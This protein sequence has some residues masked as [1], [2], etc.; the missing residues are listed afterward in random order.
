MRPIPTGEEGLL[1]S[2]STFPIAGG[3]NG[4]RPRNTARRRP[5]SREIA[6]PADRRH[7]HIH[8]AHDRAAGVDNLDRPRSRRSLGC[9]MER[10][11]ALG[12]AVVL[13][14]LEERRQEHLSALCRLGPAGQRGDRGRDRLRLTLAPNAGLSQNALAP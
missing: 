10:L 3:S 11:S 2:W 9:L 4:S 7:V 13:L 8:A 12:P 1:S 14:R 6:A 5:S